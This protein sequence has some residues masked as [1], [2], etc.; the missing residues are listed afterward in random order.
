MQVLVERAVSGELFEQVGFTF[1]GRRRTRG[2]APTPCARSRRNWAELRE[3]HQEAQFE[4][5]DQFVL[6]VRRGAQ[7]F[8]LTGDFRRGAQCE[9]TA[10]GLEILHPFDIE[11]EEVLVEDAIRQVGT[12]VERTPVVD[13]VQRIQRHETGAQISLRGP[14]R[15]RPPDR[16]KSPQP[17]L[18]VIGTHAVKADRDAGGASAAC[19]RFRSPV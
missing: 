9:R 2:R 14:T 3:F 11:I 18:P 8:D 6:H 1:A 4:A 16:A 13:G 10:A 7:S 15:S 5:A 19:P 17:Q 12:G